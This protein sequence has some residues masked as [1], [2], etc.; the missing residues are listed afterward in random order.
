M[1]LNFLLIFSI[2][3]LSNSSYSQNSNFSIGVE[4]NFGQTELWYYNNGSVSALVE[5]TFK[6]EEDP[7][8][9]YDIG[10]I[11]EYKVSETI[12]I[13]AGVKY[14][15]LGYERNSNA[16]VFPQPDPSQPTS[17]R[18][19]YDNTYIEVPLRINY[20]I[21]TKSGSFFICSG[22]SPNINLN[23]FQTTRL[24]YS[25][26]IESTKSEDMS[27]EF[28]KMNIVVQFGIGWEI[29][30]K[31]KLKFYLMPNYKSQL[32]GIAQEANLNRSIMQYGIAIGLTFN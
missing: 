14:V 4:A 11:I 31:N 12:G 29:E 17:L 25:D 9:G 8:F 7:S 19:I 28:R 16:L 5:E 30:I 15:E 32:F 24:T 6:K 26:R 27:I 18:R 21:N 22:L 2:L 20:Y 1:K 23:N 3:F 13:L 10:L